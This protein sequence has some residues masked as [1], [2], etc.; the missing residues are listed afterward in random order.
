[1]WLVGSEYQGEGDVTFN[2]TNADVTLHLLLGGL[3]EIKGLVKSDDPQAKVPSGVMIGI[4][5]HEA[6]QGSDVDAAGHFTFGRVLPGGYD[7][8]F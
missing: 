1:V 4:E 6:A 7:S 5:S 2:V 8:N 3:G